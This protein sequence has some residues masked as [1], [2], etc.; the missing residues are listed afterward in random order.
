MAKG[1]TED[2]PDYSVVTPFARSENPGMPGPF[3][4]RVVRVR[5]QNCVDEDTERIDVP[6]VT[7]MISRGI[8]EVTGDRDDR[9]SW[10][11]FF[12]SEDTVGIKVNSSGAP[13]K[14][15]SRPEVVAE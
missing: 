8:S 5:S 15:I 12:S 6:T 9:D 7:Q 2:V 13:T 4:G 10:R 14:M 3:P 11:R 1:Q